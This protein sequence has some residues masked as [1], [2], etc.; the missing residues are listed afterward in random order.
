MDSLKDIFSG[1]GKSKDNAYLGIDIGSS[2]IKIVQLKN[3]KGRIILETYGEVAL[4]PY[5]ENEQASKKKEEKVFRSAGELTHLKVEALG[6]AL[7]NLLDQANANAKNVFISLPSA[8]SLIFT[9]KLPKI[10]E[11]KIAGAVET[12]AKRYIPVP[13]SEIS[14]DWW[15]IPER[16]IYEDEDNLSGTTNRNEIEVLVAAVRNEILDEYHELYELFKDR[17]NQPNFE[18]ET[19]SAM[20]GALQ[21]ELSPVLLIDFG[22]SGMRM[23]IIEHG[24]VRNFHSVNRG[25]AYLSSS[26]QKSLQISFDEAEKLKREV[27]LLQDQEQ[28]R[29]AESAKIITA[30]TNYLFSEIKNMLFHFEKE[31]HKPISKIILT[32][33]G[34]LLPGFREEIELRNNITTVYAQPFKKVVSPDFLE[35]V[36]EKAGPEFT[37]AI[38]LALQELR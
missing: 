17:F 4:G 26:L 21:H 37:N 10:E 16:E 5:E 9:L 29:R 33:G 20:R 13:L 2:Y 38:G 11:R 31:H 36:L 15:I 14:L 32:G 30:G 34:S 27:G 22:A 28:E 3:E 6:E 1:L 35:E 18:I 7:K 24:V 23:V 8:S 19:F 25:S 12:E